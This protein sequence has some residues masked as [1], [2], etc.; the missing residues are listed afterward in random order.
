MR[1]L[2]P[3]CIVTRLGVGK[4]QHFVRLAARRRIEFLPVRRR[5]A[6][7]DTVLIPCARHQPLELRR[8]LTDLNVIICKPL[9]RHGIAAHDFLRPLHTHLNHLLVDGRCHFPH[10][11]A[12]P[13]RVRRYELPQTFHIQC[14]RELAQCRIPKC[15]Q[16]AE[17]PECRTAKSEHPRRS[18]RLDK[19]AS[20]HCIVICHPFTPLYMHSHSKLMETVYSRSHAPLMSVYAP[21]HAA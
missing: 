13:S 19:S 7:R 3:V 20:I 15:T 14:S 1:E 6:R 8:I 18:S 17:L 21:L 12:P 2:L 11:D 10:Q 4:D 5:T 9:I 16:P